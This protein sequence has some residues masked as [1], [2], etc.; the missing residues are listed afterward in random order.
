MDE[1]VA[2]SRETTGNTPI[3]IAGD[4]N[5]KPALQSLTLRSLARASFVDALGDAEKRGPTS[6]GQAHAI[7]WIFAKHTVPVRGRIIDAPKASDHSPVM[8]AFGRAPSL[9]AG[10]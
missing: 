3:L 10:R 6:L 5:N 4:F 8:A 9:S 2:D 1:I 7:D